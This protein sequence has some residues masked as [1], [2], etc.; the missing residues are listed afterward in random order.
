MKG[1]AWLGMLLSCACGRIGFDDHG[2]DENPTALG[3]G[4]TSGESGDSDD[5]GV[6]GDGGTTSTIDCVDLN[7]GSI[8][9]ANVASGSTSGAGNN[10]SSRT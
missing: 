1:A 3:D 10:Y 4:G 8:M 5:S 9:G 7:L 6:L 2:D